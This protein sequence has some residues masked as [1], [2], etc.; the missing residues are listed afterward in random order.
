[1]NC[2]RFHFSKPFGESPVARSI[3][4]FVAHRRVAFAERVLSALWPCTYAEC[5]VPFSNAH[6][7]GAYLNGNI[8]ARFNAQ[9][10]LP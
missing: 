6:S 9:K 1:M 10:N 4:S 5:L 2:A 7:N 3:A 8:F